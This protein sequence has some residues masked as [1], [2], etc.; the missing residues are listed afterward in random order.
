MIAHSNW[1]NQINAILIL[2]LHS[3]I[4]RS[5]N[6]NLFLLNENVV[7]CQYAR[8]G[9][10]DLLS[11]APPSNKMWFGWRDND[12]KALIY[13][14]LT[15]HHRGKRKPSFATSRLIEFSIPKQHKIEKGLCYFKLPAGRTAASEWGTQ[16][17]IPS[18]RTSRTSQHLGKSIRR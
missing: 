16:W 5:I 8:L 13:L 15:G 2:D 4:C 14:G 3:M 1:T 17:V 7:I 12:N 11:L 6:L 18:G 10:A 9:W